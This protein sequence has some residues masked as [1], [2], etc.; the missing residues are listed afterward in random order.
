MWTYCAMSWTLKFRFFLYDILLL[1]QPL[2]VYGLSSISVRLE[3][4]INLGKAIH[5][6]PSAT[7]GVPSRRLIYYSSNLILEMPSGNDNAFNVECPLN[8]PPPVSIGRACQCHH[9]TQG[10]QF[11]CRRAILLQVVGSIFAWQLSI[12]GMTLL[13][14]GRRVLLE[15]WSQNT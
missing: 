7:W 9:F 8:P 11:R 15:D 4:N 2:S 13:C 6:A 10:L 5:A 1:A 12:Q 3:G 14:G